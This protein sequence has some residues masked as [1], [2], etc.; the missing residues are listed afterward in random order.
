S[1]GQ[2]ASVVVKTRDD[3]RPLRYAG[4]D[5]IVGDIERC[6]V[7]YRLRGDTVRLKGLWVTRSHTGFRSLVGGFD[8]DE[9]AL[10]SNDASDIS[11]VGPEQA[12]GTREDRVEHR[13]HVCLG[14][15][16]DAQDVAGRGLRV[17]R[18]R[19]FA[20]ARLQLRE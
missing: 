7:A 16:D 18:R 20:V 12:H 8:R 11:N 4:I 3:P 5:L 6:T 19:E 14:A 13:L 2:A 1:D 10:I 15:A 9:F 17:E